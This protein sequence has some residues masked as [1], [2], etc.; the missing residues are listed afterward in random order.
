MSKRK[1]HNKQARMKKIFV[2]LSLILCLLVHSAEAASFFVCYR[3][4]LIPEDGLD[5]GCVKCSSVQ[6]S[7]DPNEYDV[8]KLCPN[9]LGKDF[10]R[11]DQAIDWKTKNCGCP[12]KGFR[13]GIL[14][15]VP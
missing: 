5:V 4:I 13:P 9:G 12:R 1:R 2:F 15:A 11:L 8:S 10:T 6:P 14:P 7:P 3:L